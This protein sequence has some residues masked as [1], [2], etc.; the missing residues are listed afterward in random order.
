M[1]MN[2]SVLIWATSIAPHEEDDAVGDFRDD[3]HQNIGS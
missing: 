3:A 2:N 1:A